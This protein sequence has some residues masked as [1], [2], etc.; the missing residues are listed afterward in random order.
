MK[1]D[2]RQS[3]KNNTEYKKS[4]SVGAKARNNTSNKTNSIGFDD[5]NNDSF[6]LKDC[7]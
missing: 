4:N 7:K 6:K 3:K 1:K 2:K 5:D